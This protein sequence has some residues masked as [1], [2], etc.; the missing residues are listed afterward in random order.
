MELML[1]FFIAVFSICFLVYVLR[2]V[3]KE[4]LLL[5]YSLLWLVLGLA[6]LFLDC[7]PDI[8]YDLAFISGF[9]TPS[10]F[11]IV[12]ALSILA[13]ICLSLSKTISKQSN[14]IKNLSQRIGILENEIKHLIDM[15]NK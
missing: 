7:F 4:K 15:S 12:I 1:R 14:S 10:N 9:L 2:L 5:R 8:A 3:A 11:V 13:L 6:V